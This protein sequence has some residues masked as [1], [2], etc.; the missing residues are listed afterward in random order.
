MEEEGAGEG[1]MPS[2]GGGRSYLLQRN[3]RVPGAGR[4]AAGDV[5][6]TPVKR[7]QRRR[8]RRGV[9]GRE[10]VLCR[11]N[12]MSP[13][14]DGDGADGGGRRWGLVTTTDS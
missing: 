9:T 8:W 11:R 3:P 2:H 14:L 4:I 13:A 6:G 7:G 10:G 1:G 12:P 5:G